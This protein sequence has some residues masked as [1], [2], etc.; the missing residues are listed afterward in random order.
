MKNWVSASAAKPQIDKT[1]NWN[2]ENGVSERVVVWLEDE[3]L[4]DF[5]RY[6][7]QID[8]WSVEGRR[9][10]DQKKVKF[11]QPIANPYKLGI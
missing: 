8:L 4:P 3:S 6:N 9:G 11:W 5:A 2:E 1:D 10:F 7:H